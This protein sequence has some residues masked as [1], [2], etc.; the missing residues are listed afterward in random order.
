[1]I[2]VNEPHLYISYHQDGKEIVLGPYYT[3]TFAKVDING[4]RIAYNVQTKDR[5]Y[6]EVIVPLWWHSITATIDPETG[7]DIR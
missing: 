7:L 3:A 1:M 5:Q 4:Q 6:T 2:H